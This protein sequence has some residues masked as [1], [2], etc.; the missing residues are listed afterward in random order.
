[1]LVKEADEIVSEVVGGVLI[2]LD[3]TVDLISAWC[4]KMWSRG[5]PQRSTIVPIN[6]SNKSVGCKETY[7]SGQ[8]AVYSA[9]EETI[10]EK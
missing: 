9:G 10:A 7:S 5:R 4:K 8:Q 3:G 6:S 2:N 1:M